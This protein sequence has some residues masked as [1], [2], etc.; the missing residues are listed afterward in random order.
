MCP[1]LRPN[2]CTDLFSGTPDGTT[3]VNMVEKVLK[4]TFEELSLEY[5]DMVQKI[6][7]EFQN[8]DLES[9]IKT[10]NKAILKSPLPKLS[11]LEEKDTEVQ[12][13]MFW[14]TVHEVVHQAL[15][16]QS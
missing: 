14:G 6:E 2:F 4:V 3:I 10:R 15:V 9:F 7:D 12:R 1:T 5:G 13:R 8:K 16:N 11:E